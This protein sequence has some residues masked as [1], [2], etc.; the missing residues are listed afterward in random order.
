MGDG[1]DSDEDCID[2]DNSSDL[3]DGELEV[4]KGKKKSNSATRKIFPDVDDEDDCEGIDDSDDDDDEDEGT[5][6]E[7]D[8]EY[9]GEEDDSAKKDEDSEYSKDDKDTEIQDKLIEA[10]LKKEAKAKAGEKKD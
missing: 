5:S 9:A 1:D 10:T 3:E 8:D 2:D 6:L 4:L 7:E